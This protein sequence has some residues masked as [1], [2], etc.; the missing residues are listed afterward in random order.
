MLDAALVG[1]VNHDVGN[2]EVI[3]INQ[4]P[5]GDSARVVPLTAETFLMVKNLEDGST[6]VG[7]CNRGEIAAEV[8]VKWSD[9]S[10]GG[11]QHLRDLWRQRDL[12][13][14]NGHFKAN[15]PRHGVLLVRMRMVN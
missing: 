2:P 4:D 8:A 10:L 7:L 5:L 9:L 12:G 6:A 15:V 13:E 14:Y 11:K 3:E 1:R